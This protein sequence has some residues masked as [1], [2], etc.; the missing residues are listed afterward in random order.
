MLRR[1]LRASLLEGWPKAI[2]EPHRAGQLTQEY[3]PDADADWNATFMIQILPFINTGQE[4]IG[5][6]KPEVWADMVENLEGMGM[7]DQSVDPTEVYTMRFLEEL[8]GGN[9]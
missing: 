1:F 8:R 7:L 3:L 2:L 9:Q 4:R 5:W 6:L